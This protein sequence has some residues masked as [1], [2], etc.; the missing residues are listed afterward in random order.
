MIEV[1]TLADLQHPSI[2]KLFDFH[3]QEDSG[4]MMLLYERLYHGRL[5]RLLYGKS[6]EHLLDWNEKSDFS[7]C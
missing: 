7:A 1:N 5:D 4:C 2:S 3:A 6:G